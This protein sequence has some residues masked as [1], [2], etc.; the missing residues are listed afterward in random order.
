MGDA[1]EFDDDHMAHSEGQ[2]N[3]PRTL[4][5]AISAFTRVFDALWPFAAWR[6]AEPGS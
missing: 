4:R 6:A 5:S 3:L 2:R 1:L